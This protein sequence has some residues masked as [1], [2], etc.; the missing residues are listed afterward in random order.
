MKD[1]NVAAILALFMGGIGVHKFYLG[2]TGAG[3]IYLLFCWTFIPSILGFIEFIILALMDKQEFDRRFNGSYTL[4]PSPVV[5]NMLPP[6][7]GYQAPHAYPPQG[8]YGHPVQ[9][10]G[11]PPQPYAQ[12]P[13][14]VPQGSGEDVVARLEKLNELRIAGLLTDEE[15]AKQKERILQSV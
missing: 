1:K 5:V 3:L 14:P 11:Y 2:Q 8:G 9:H 4:G 7:G 12:R 10:P 6:A 13:Q 15:F